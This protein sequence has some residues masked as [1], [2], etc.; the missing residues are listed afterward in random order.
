MK[1]VYLLHY[2]QPIGDLANPHGRA[3]HYIGYTDDL[4]KRL[5]Q[6]RK[7]Q[8]GAG[9]VKAFYQAGIH[10][11]LAR[12]WDGGRDLERKLK[13]RKEAPRLCPICHHNHLEN[14]EWRKEL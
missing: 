14:E 10:F 5:E 7:G 8:S 3:Q 11:E 4:D 1:C 12:V 6:H 2:D 9:I 13:N